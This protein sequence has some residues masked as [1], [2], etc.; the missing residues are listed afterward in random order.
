MAA[1]FPTGE[2]IEHPLEASAAAGRTNLNN[3]SRSDFIKRLSSYANWPV[4]AARGVYPS[5]LASA[6]FRYTTFKDA[7]KCDTCD[8]EI[9]GWKDDD[10]P[11]R[12]HLHKSP[13]CAFVKEA[14]VEEDLNDIEIDGEE[15]T[16]EE[17]DLANHAQLVK[18]LKLYNKCN[19][20]RGKYTYSSHITIII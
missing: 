4:A 19:K 17:V 5:D 16:Y 15:E 11:L 14:V 1:N 10:I 6:G 18:D 9:S 20:T 3:T 13:N 7:V 2:S 12:I 8:L